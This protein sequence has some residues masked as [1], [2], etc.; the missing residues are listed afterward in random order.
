QLKEC[1]KTRHRSELSE[2]KF[3]LIASGTSIYS[4]GYLLPLMHAI[5][6]PSTRVLL[7]PSVSQ[8][9]FADR[10]GRFVRRYFQHATVY[11]DDFLTSVHRSG[12]APFC[13]GSCPL[14]QLSGPRKERYPGVAR[15]GWRLL[16]GPAACSTAAEAEV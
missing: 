12:W 13:E 6:K 5:S 8:K 9:K 1:M 7:A 11:P 2:L 14:Y 16:P 3:D 4:A 10:W 15:D